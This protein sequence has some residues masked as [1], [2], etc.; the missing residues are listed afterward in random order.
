MG[1]RKEKNITPMEN[2]YTKQQMMKEK[3]MARRKKLLFRRLAVFSIIALASVYLLVSTLILRNHQL[4][5]K[6]AEKAKLEKKLADLKK[7]KTY[8]QD[9]VVKLNDDN[10]IAKLARSEYFLSEKGEIIFNIP[11]DKKKKDE[12]K[13][14]SY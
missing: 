8:L 11:D 10:Y 6:Q 13:D 14:V 3:V 4:E 1:V 2:A 9:E 7:K 5:V 12:D